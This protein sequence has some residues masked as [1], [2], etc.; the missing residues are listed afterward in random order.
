M[1]YATEHQEPQM[2]FVD[3]VQHN[4][5][6]MLQRVVIE[7]EVYNIFYDSGAG[8]FVSRHSAIQRL[9]KLAYQTMMGPLIMRGV[10]DIVVKA[11]HG[12]YGVTLPLADGGSIS[13]NGM[14]LE[15][16][17]ETFPEYQLKDRIE[18]DIQQS[19]QKAGGYL[20]DLPILS[21]VVGGDTDMM[22]GSK[23]RCIYPIEIFRLPSGLSIC[24]SFFKNV[25]GSRGVICGPHEV[26]DLID[27]TYNHQASTFLTQ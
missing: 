2:P 22:I 18:K 1:S 20:H 24:Q 6:Y 16:L 15:T 10:G 5:V 11:P 17:T 23:Y 4:A 27:K 7:G 19:Y 13:M 3:S 21:E 12:M 14:C 25:D 8:D 9:S 26:I